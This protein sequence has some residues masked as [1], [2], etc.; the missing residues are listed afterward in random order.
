V[1]AFTACWFLL[2]HLARQRHQLPTPAVSVALP[3]FAA[4]YRAAAPLLLSAVQQSTDISCRPGAQQQARSS[5][6]RVMGHT[7]E[8]QTDGH[9]IIS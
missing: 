9:P 6:V 5:G 2:R 8:G 7:D 4:E 1:L 3:A